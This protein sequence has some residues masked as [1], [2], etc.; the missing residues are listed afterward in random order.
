MPGRTGGEL[1]VDHPRTRW[2]GQGVIGSAAA[3]DRRP[4]LTRTALDRR[5]HVPVARFYPWRAVPAEAARASD[6]LPAG[7]PGVMCS[8]EPRDQRGWGASGTGE[9]PLG[10]NVGP[11]R[12]RFMTLA[13]G[14][15][16]RDLENYLELEVDDSLFAG[17]LAFDA[18]V[19]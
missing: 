10:P 16:G 6:D 15:R 11:E 14:A 12:A 2:G 7:P 4:T 19:E 1:G 17:E 18:V 5:H 3:V 13:K 9:V 8:E